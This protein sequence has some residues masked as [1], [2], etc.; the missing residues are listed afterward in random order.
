MLLL[1]M[2][3]KMKLTRLPPFLLLSALLVL[4]GCN[5]TIGL[6]KSQQNIHIPSW[7]VKPIQNDT[8]GFIGAA[9]KYDSQGRINIAGSRKAALV[10]LQSYHQL[11]ITNIDKQLL[12]DAAKLHLPSGNTVRFLPEF[13]YQGVVYSYATLEQDQFSLSQQQTLTS[14]SHCEF[15]QCNPEWLCDEQSNTI[16]GVSFYTATPSQQLLMAQ[17]NAN[18]IAD[19]LTKSQVHAT[20]FIS[21]SADTN[22]NRHSTSFNQQSD[23]KATVKQHHAMLLSELCEYQGTLIGNFVLPKAPLAL[24][25]NWQSLSLYQ[26]RSVI[27]GSFGQG[28]TMS[29]DLLLSSAIELAIKDALIELAKIKGIAI[30]NTSSLSFNDGAY[31]LSK[32]KMTVDEQ[33]SGQL[34]DI[35]L[36]YQKDN[37]VVNVWVLE[38]NNQL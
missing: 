24:Q 7:F 12:T 23:V 4:G 16:T 18:L 34:L 29:S 31:F 13:F 27:Q 22:A 37:P 15:K 26:D 3:S 35:R 8:V 20:E 11:S 6:N 5:A 30:E 25:E 1:R 17:Q 10:K 2:N 36:S 32:S 28:G 9:T 33:V 38:N 21:Q 14:L 19:L